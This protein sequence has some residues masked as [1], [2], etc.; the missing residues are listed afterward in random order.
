MAGE[1]LGKGTKSVEMSWKTSITCR[2]WASLAC[3]SCL[4]SF[5]GI[6][7]V[8][9]MGV[10]LAAFGGGELKGDAISRVLL[11]LWR[12]CYFGLASPRCTCAVLINTRTVG[13]S[14]STIARSILTNI[15][16]ERISIYNI[17]TQNVLS[18]PCPHRL[19]SMRPCKILQHQPPRILHQLPLPNLSQTLRCAFHHLR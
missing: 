13:Y 18:K 3:L 14:I 5:S 7:A 17:N 4:V 19:M 9:N 15:L 2:A 10:G 1:V 8:G 12:S 6:L 11:C 16:E